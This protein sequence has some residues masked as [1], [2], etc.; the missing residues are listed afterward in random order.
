MTIEE[1]NINK[2]K[3][4]FDSILGLDKDTEGS[5]PGKPGDGGEENQ[6]NLED[7]KVAIATL[8]EKFDNQV[9]IGRQQAEQIKKMQTGDGLLDMIQGQLSKQSPE[10]KAEADKLA[11]QSKHDGDPVGVTEDMITRAVE[12]VVT[13]IQAQLNQEVTARQGREVMDQ[14]NKEYDIDWPKDGAKVTEQLKQFSEDARIK[15]PRGVLL[16]AMNLAGVGTKRPEMPHLGG[17]EGIGAAP[18]IQTQKE[19]YKTA[20]KAGIERVRKEENEGVYN[21]L[22]NGVM[23][24]Q[25]VQT[26]IQTVKK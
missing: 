7:P 24:G 9:E 19:E 26:G 3:G 10:A 12:K 1:D 5:D 20:I 22:L 21:S 14:V 4:A 2:E 16:K 15:D 8:Q 13:P 6:E 18:S 11:L 25:S 23:N 17:R